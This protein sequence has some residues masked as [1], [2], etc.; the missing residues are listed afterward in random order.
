MKDKYRLLCSK[1]AHH[2]RQYILK[3]IFIYVTQNFYSVIKIFS[4]FKIFTQLLNLLTSCGRQVLSYLVF[5]LYTYR[6][7]TSYFFVLVQQHIL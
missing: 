3:E 1:G 4:I 5:L 2:Y 7:Y 6:L